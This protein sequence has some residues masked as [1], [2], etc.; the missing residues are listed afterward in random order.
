MASA[1]PFTTRLLRH[2]LPPGTVGTVASLGEELRARTQHTGK[3][4][5]AMIDAASGALVG[6]V[7]EGSSSKV[8]ITPH[9]QLL[10]AAGAY[11]QLHTHPSPLSFSRHDVALLINTPPIRSMIVYAQGTRC[12]AMTKSAQWDRLLGKTSP[13]GLTRRM[14]E[15]YEEA[16]GSRAIRQT[17]RAHQVRGDAD[18]AAIDAIWGAIAPRLSLRYISY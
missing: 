14:V 6:A 17:Y 2:G 5:A 12:Y 11:V 8:D 13:E 3:E 1:P 10:A 18:A 15:L 4:Y 9:L 7:L 16:R